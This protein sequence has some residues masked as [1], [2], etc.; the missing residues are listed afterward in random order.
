[1]AGKGF[2]WILEGGGRRDGRLTQALASLL[3]VIFLMCMVLWGF[4]GLKAVPDVVGMTKAEAKE[5]LERAGLTLGD[6]TPKASDTA[7]GGEVVEQ[8]MDAGMRVMA[9]TPVDIV[10]V[11]GG[12]TVVE[13]STEPGDGK[14]AAAPE[15]P[16]WTGN[17]PREETIVPYDSAALPSG[18]QVPNV[19]GMGRSAALSALSAVGFKGSVS[20]G[21]TTTDVPVDTVY[22]QK[23]SAGSYQSAGS[24]IVIYLSEGAPTSGAPYDKAPYE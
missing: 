2:G 4:S 20:S 3:L 12:S 5:A 14:K 11:D 1:M 23:P 17:P 13:G 22:A 6:A 24:T 9:G 10:F 16:G 7:E 19:M 8:S 15:V 18:V 21:K